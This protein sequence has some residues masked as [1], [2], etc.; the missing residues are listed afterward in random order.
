MLAAP[1][2]MLSRLIPSRPLR[3]PQIFSPRVSPDDPRIF[4]FNNER[5]QIIDEVVA[6]AVEQ[7]SRDPRRLLY[8]LNDAAN[9]EVRRLS[10][11]RDAEAELSL[12]DW[13]KLLRRLGKMS[14]D[15]RREALRQRVRVMARDIAGNFD[16]RVFRT[17]RRLVPGVLTAIMDPSALPHE[18]L[19]AGW[20]RL[21]ALATVEG[22]V[23]KLQALAKIG[24][25]VLVPTHSS[26][27][28]SIALGYLVDREGLPPVVYGAGKNLFSN[29]IVSFFMHNLGAYRIDR[30]IGAR[31]YKDVLKTY[32]CLMIERG[33][34]SLFFPGG[35]RSRSGMVE[36]RVK[37]GLAGTAIEAFARNL[38]RGVRRPVYIVPT[39]INYALVLEA[40]TL[41]EDWLKGAGQARY[42]IE[43]DEFSRYER[44]LAFAKKL[45]A[46]RSAAVVRFADP[47][48]PFGN[49]VDEAGRSLAPGGRVIDPASY[50]SRGGVPSV[51]AARD[52]GYTRE[53][54]EALP[55]RYA[56]ETVIMWTQLVAH[57]LYRRLVV[58]SP[59]ID[60]FGRQRRR[61]EVMMPRAELIAE[62]E[63]ARD[64]LL[65]LEL[66]GQVRLGPVLR[67]ESA[68][69]A[70]TLALEAWRGYH[71]R[72]IATAR[73][74]EVVI[75]DPNLLLFYQNR[76]VGFA[77]ALARPETLAAS[78]E[79]AALEGRR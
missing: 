70:V 36:S 72:P 66:A 37:L 6:R 10:S 43:D 22:P 61:G 73:G 53:L 16:V 25:L 55:G 21:D 9:L 47:I 15:D 52:A 17:T 28:D 75:E 30:R 18:A 60:L 78:R 4:T 69:S 20:P 57:V 26:N 34:H 46:L 63:E 59:G 11:Q 5:D 49:E 62:V 68:E 29:P 24:T 3:M 27:L 65:S 39:T 64:R 19:R 8:L 45:P 35:T 2:S 14:D 74:D 79:I 67:A 71:T 32:S 50:V 51:D 12:A 41:I 40:E 1:M 77:E 76:L 54:G 23:A 58:E 31:L 42:I 38:T 33:Y 7:H 48:D 44:V 13:Q 56:R